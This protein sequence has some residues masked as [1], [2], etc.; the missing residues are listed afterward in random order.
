MK[1]ALCIGHLSYDITLPLDGYPEEN[2]KY[3]I[4]STLESSGGPAANAAALLA[5]WASKLPLWE[6]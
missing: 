1:R 4:E 5:L 3:Q 2:T 6:H